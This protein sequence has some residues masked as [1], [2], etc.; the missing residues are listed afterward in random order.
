MK[1]PSNSE[2]TNRRDLLKRVG[3]AV[4]GGYL[5]T[6]RGYA[7]NE[8]IRVG[9]IGTGHRCQVLMKALVQIPGAKI[10]AICDIWEQALRDAQKIAGPDATPFKDYRALLD[11]KDIDAVLIGSPNHQHVTMVAAACS[12]GEDVYVEKPLTHHL[13]RRPARRWRQGSSAASAAHL[14]NIALR[15]G[16]A[17]HWK[18]HGVHSGMEG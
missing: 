1:S 6:A 2:V 4:T 11:R 7:A 9:C 8:T 5:A 3:L 12:A 14:G 16:G 15:E 17:A 18:D 13:G 10:V